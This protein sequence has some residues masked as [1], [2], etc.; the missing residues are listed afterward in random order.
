M[1]NALADGEPIIYCNERFC[2]MV[3][4]SRAEIMQKPAAAEFL[5][6][7]LTAPES[8]A[9]VRETLAG[10][11]ERQIDILYY[12]KDGKSRPLLVDPAVLATRAPINRPVEA[13]VPART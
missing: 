11:E 10:A 4:F 5:H 13:A 8:A 7:P 1:A 2:Q 6:G 3:G 12:R 9:L